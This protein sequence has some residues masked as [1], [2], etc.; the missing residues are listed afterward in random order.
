MHIILSVFNVAVNAVAGLLVAVIGAHVNGSGAT[1][2]VA[3]L[4][5]LGGAIK[6]GIIN[7]SILTERA[8]VDREWVLPVVCVA[9]TFVASVCATVV[10]SQ[11][12]IGRSRFFDHH[13]CRIEKKQCFADEFARGGWEEQLRISCCWRHWRR[14]LR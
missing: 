3:A 14:G 12:G 4:G 11:V 13:E 1:G 2:Q 6:T 9:A 8:L 10:V 7:G 5:A